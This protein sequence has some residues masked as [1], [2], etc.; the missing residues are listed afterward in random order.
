MEGGKIIVF[1]V[2]SFF[3][4]G[5]IQLTHAQAEGKKITSSQVREFLLIIGLTAGILIFG[6][7]MMFLI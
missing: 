3:A 2:I 6:K 5:L 7:L 4:I 1:L